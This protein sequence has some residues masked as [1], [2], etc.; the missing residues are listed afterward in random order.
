[1][2][3][4]CRAR[5]SFFSSLTQK[6][7]D[8]RI[9]QEAKE[10][11]AEELYNRRGR[12]EAGSPLDYYLK[13]QGSRGGHWAAANPVAA[14]V[15]DMRDV[16]RSVLFVPCHKQKALSKIAQIGNNVDLFILDL[17]DSVPPESKQL[18]RNQL[19]QFVNGG[20][21]VLRNSTN[22]KKRSRA[23]VR[24]NSLRAD[25]VNGLLDLETVLG[26]SDV[27]G[28]GI[29][30]VEVGDE[31][32][33][34]EYLQPGGAGTATTHQVWAFFETP[35]SIL[36]ADKICSTNFYQ[37]GVMGLNDLSTEMGYPLQ[38]A[39]GGDG[40]LSSSSPLLGRVQHYY[41]MSVVVTACRAHGMIPLDGVFNDP[42]D[43]V[44]FQ[45]ELA[46]SR[47]F[48]FDG[49]TLIHPAQVL[50]CNDAF[51]PTQAEVEWAERVVK[52]V[53]HAGKGVAVLDGKMVEEL[54]ARQAS[55]VLARR[56]SPVE[57]TA[58]ASSDKSSNS[59]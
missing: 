7:H 16:P 56:P 49:K 19:H 44:G 28:V 26:L 43:K 4:R 42:T 27:E 31:E 34:S 14:K 48:G 29:P 1:M 9:K 24:I 3:C 57:T 22:N 8:S 10:D 46:E 45:A 12:N 21:L 40:K 32:A 20:G 13:Q 15:T 11:A 5:L 18:A 33:L 47:R 23:I 41:A 59:V 35:R 36:D 37:Y 25:P 54:H 53:E 17:E 6:L 39:G 58:T 55:K 30:K 52:C 50:D 38:G 2:F 51:T